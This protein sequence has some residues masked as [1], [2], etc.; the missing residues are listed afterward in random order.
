MTLPRPS[1]PFP[2]RRLLLYKHQLAQYLLPQSLKLLEFSC[3]NS[4]TVQYYLRS[5]GVA[6]RN[7]RGGVVAFPIAPAITNRMNIRD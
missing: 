4:S 3:N 6:P 2:S 7:L 1:P 5:H